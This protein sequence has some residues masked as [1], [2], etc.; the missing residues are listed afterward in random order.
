ME[1][2]IIDQLAGAGLKPPKAVTLAITNR[3]NLSCAHCWPASGP[4]QLDSEV[5]KDRVEALMGGFAAL[6]AETFTLT[7]GEPLTHPH[8]MELLDS[9]CS[10]PGIR[11][12]RLQTNVILITQAHIK[13]FSR[14][15]ERGLIIQTSLEGATAATHDRVRGA[16]SFMRTLQGLR[17]LE[18]NGLAS[19]VCITFTEMEH[20]F[21]ELPDLLVMA[22]AMGVRQFITGTLVSGGRAKEQGGLAPPTPRQYEHLLKR[23]RNDKAFKESYK[24][25]GNIAPLEWAASKPDVSAACCTFIETP[26]VTAEGRFYPCVMLQADACAA[27]G[28]YDRPLSQAI[29]E[30]IPSWSRLQEISRQRLTQLKS[31]QDCRAYSRCGAGCMGRAY[32]ADGEFFCVEDRCLLRQ[33]VYRNIG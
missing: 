21:E 19:R 10:I 27:T 8:W 31:C 11:E 15:K 4:D 22:D 30:M 28:V 13:I 32:S 6:G 17:L 9:A 5:P 12:V 33:A 23:Y 3:C 2:R 7:G 29:H 26:Y 1:D 25:I 14:L 18:K 24:R 20:N 16:G